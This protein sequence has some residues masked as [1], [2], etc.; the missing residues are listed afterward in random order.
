MMKLVLI[1]KK[2]TK[3]ECGEFLE[4]DPKTGKMVCPECDAKPLKSKKK[5]KKSEGK[6]PWEKDKK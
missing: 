1:A 3:C 6:K 2:V 5:D 4:E